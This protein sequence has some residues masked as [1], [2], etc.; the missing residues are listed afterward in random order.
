MWSWIL[1]ILI[2]L[3]AL[4]GAALVSLVVRM[5]GDAAIQLSPFMLQTVVVLGSLASAVL[6]V[7]ALFTVLSPPHDRASPG[8]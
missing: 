7:A 8:R 5:I 2:A 3:A 1:R 6:V 4:A